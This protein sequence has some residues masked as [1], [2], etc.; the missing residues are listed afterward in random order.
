MFHWNCVLLISYPHLHENCMW[1][2]VKYKL[3]K[4]DEKKIFQSITDFSAQQ[5]WKGWNA[6][7]LTEVKTNV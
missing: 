5:K 7:E 2:S 4:L 1:V 3:A 6:S